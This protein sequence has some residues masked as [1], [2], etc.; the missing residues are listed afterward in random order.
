M[1]KKLY[2]FYYKKQHKKTGET[3]GKYWFTN[4]QKIFFLT[5]KNHFNL[6][7]KL[8]KNDNEFWQNLMTKI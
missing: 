2:F 6:F 1:S 5:R 7:K 3:H 4:S 8:L